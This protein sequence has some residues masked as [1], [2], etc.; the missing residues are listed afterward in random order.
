MSTGRSIRLFL[1]DGV[2]T[3][4]IT[5]EIVNWTGHIV[6]APRS[7]LPDFLLREEASRTGVYFLVG[8]DS[9]QGLLPKVYIGESDNIGQRLK[10]HN[11]SED[12]G[13]KDFWDAFYSIT[14]KDMNLTKAH[15]RYLES[16]LILISMQAKLCVLQNATAPET[17]RLPEADISDMEYFIQQI[18]TILP[19]LSLDVLRDP[20]L[21]SSS[22]MT[23]S[24]ELNGTIIDS[25]NDASVSSPV[26]EL[27]LDKRGGSPLRAE[28]QELHGEFIVFAGSYVRP[29][30]PSATYNYRTLRQELIRNGVIMPHESGYCFNESYSFKSP[31]AASA[32]ILD[33]SDNGRT[34]WRVKGL[35]MTYGDWQ[36]SRIAAATLTADGGG[37][38]SQ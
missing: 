25:Q 8:I 9:S 16:R 3:G 23:S 11:Q 7:R 33:R 19:V 37:E 13:G 32:V 4:V 28:A 2:S 34:S 36:N 14:S 29:D 24:T 1:A 35:D 21:Q 18:K 38:Q 26:F 31:S 5:A 22:A 27:Y 30:A 17:C 10:Q 15:V 6:S 20:L 12:K